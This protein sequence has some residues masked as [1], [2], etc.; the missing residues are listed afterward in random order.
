MT[1]PK[2]KVGDKFN[3]LTVLEREENTTGG[4]AQWLVQCDCED[5]NELI[6]PSNQ[7]TSGKTKSCGCLVRDRNKGKE[8]FRKN[9]LYSR[10]GTMIQRCTNENVIN[11]EYYGGRGVEV[12]QAWIDSFTE[13]RDYIKSIHPDY[14]E[15]LALKYQ[16]DRI[17]T[18]G[19]YEPGNIRLVTVSDNAKNRRPQQGPTLSRYTP[20]VNNK[21]RLNLTGQVFGELTALEPVGSNSMG[22][23]WRCSCS[24]GN[25]KEVA[26]KLLV[27]ERVKSCGHLKSVSPTKTHGLRNDPAYAVWARLRDRAKK[28]KIQIIEEW[29]DFPTFHA[30]IKTQDWGNGRLLRTKVKGE[31]Y[32]PETC[33]FKPFA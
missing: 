3:K 5:H 16:I 30:W 29:L 21:K 28:G 23:V 8:I 10:W 14:L 7:L 25:E 12:H 19:N 2:I 24:C 15:L 17:E 4:K 22:V 27:N 13:F 11:Y 9:P 18:N 6:V 33:Y 26:A 1:S 32:G 20:G 31:V